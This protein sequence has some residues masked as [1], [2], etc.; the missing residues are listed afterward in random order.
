MEDWSF[1]V[2]DFNGCQTV[3]LFSHGDPEG[4]GVSLALFSSLFVGHGCFLFTQRF[5]QR[6]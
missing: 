4:G 6:L 5:P 3:L 2:L 1:Q